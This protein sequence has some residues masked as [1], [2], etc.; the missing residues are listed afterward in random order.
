[1]AVVTVKST[2]ISNRDASPV[3]LS[4]GALTGANLKES[5]GTVAITSGD[6]IASK[7]LIC[8]VPSNAV[9]KHV[10]IEAPDI[11][12]TTAGDLGLYQTTQNGGAAADVDLFCSA[13]ALGSAAIVAGT[14][15]MYESGVYTVATSTQAVWQK[16]GLTSDPGRNYDLALTLTA[17][18]DATGTIAVSVKYTQ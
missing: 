1:M 17:A 10:G 18:A 8:E 4:S 2:Q 15:Q 3:V 16:L 11:G 9:I 5:V 13:L 6:S 7:Y 12:T 14:N